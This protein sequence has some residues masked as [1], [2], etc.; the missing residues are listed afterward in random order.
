MKLILTLL[1][2]ISFTL[3]QAYIASSDEPDYSV[4]DPSFEYVVIW[5][6]WN[7]TNS[8][9]GWNG[10]GQKPSYWSYHSKV[11]TNGIELLTWLNTNDGN[12][13]YWA[14]KGQKLVRMSDKNILSAYSLRK[15]KEI[16]LKLNKTKRTRNDTTIVNVKGKK[17]VDKEYIIKE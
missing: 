11:F 16:D 5:K 14:E 3:G 17:W 12:N 6:K 15:A 7:D 10:Q 13:Y 1:I 8:N 2:L 9:W 4:E